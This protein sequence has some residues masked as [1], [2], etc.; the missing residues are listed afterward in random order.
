MRSL[1]GSPYN[2]NRKIN[3]TQSLRNRELSQEAI[4]LLV[5][6]QNIAKI[7][8]RNNPWKMVVK[9]Y[10]FVLKMSLWN[11]I[12]KNSNLILM[13]GQILWKL[14]LKV[15]KGMK[16]NSEISFLFL[17]FTPS[18]IKRNKFKINISLL[19][20]LQMKSQGSLKNIKVIFL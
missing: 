5:L 18:T 13:K 2:I 10:S 12:S 9:N 1:K 14:T 4:I 20:I 6:F 11:N 3:K 15:K 17:Q 8:I 7:K 19:K 16:T